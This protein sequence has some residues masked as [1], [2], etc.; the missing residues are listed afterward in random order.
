MLI[1]SDLWYENANSSVCYDCMGFFSIRLWVFFFVV[2]KKSIDATIR[3]LFVCWKQKHATS[4]MARRK[5][6]VLALLLV[7]LIDFTEAQKKR[8]QRERRR[9]PTQSGPRQNTRT[10]PLSTGRRQGMI[11]GNVAFLG[12]KLCYPTFFRVVGLI[13]DFIA[14]DSICCSFLGG[15]FSSCSRHMINGPPLF[16]IFRNSKN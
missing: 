16:R 14:I 11:L 9:N 4:D 7:L 1:F 12:R 8:L 15:Q 13:I 3:P 10:R 6:L 2:W 5:R